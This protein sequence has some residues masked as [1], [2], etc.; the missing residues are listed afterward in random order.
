MTWQTK[1]KEGGGFATVFPS[2]TGTAVRNPD[3]LTAGEPACRFRDGDGVLRYVAADRT[4]AEKL[5]ATLDGLKDTAAKAAG[6]A[7]AARDTVLEATG[8]KEGVLG[9]AS[10]LLGVP[11]WILFA[12]A[13]GAGYLIVRDFLPR[14][15]AP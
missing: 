11:K 2:P 13:L 10:K 14:R 12:A 1:C 15:A 7:V 6:A 5:G 9:I 4:F 3:K 8:V